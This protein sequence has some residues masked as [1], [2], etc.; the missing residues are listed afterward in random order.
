MELI[1]HGLRGGK[2]TEIVA[3]FRAHG[4]GHLLVATEP[5]RDRIM[6]Q[7]QFTSDEGRRTIVARPDVLKGT[8]GEVFCDNLDWIISF[9]LGAAVDVATV[10]AGR[11]HGLPSAAHAEIAGLTEAA[12]NPEPHTP[13]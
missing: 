6:R 5:E 7:Y 4:R 9:F 11:Q 10:T 8:H 12:A 3:K 1:I 13:G 2:T